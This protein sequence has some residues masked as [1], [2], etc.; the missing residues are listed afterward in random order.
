MGKTRKHTNRKRQTR[1]YSG[2]TSV[3]RKMKGGLIDPPKSLRPG[4][5][6]MKTENGEEYYERI[7]N[8]VTTW[9]K[10]TGILPRGWTEEVDENGQMYY[11]QPD[12]IST[13]NLPQETMYNGSNLEDEDEDEEETLGPSVGPRGFEL[14]P[15]VAKQAPVEQPLSKEQL[16]R[17]D[18]LALVPD[19]IMYE[20]AKR[21]VDQLWKGF[22]CSGNTTSIP[23]T[24]SSD[25]KSQ[26]TMIISKLQTL[27][28]QESTVNTLAKTVLRTV[29]APQVASKE[30]T[31]TFLNTL[32]EKGTLSV[33]CK[34]AKLLALRII[35]LLELNPPEYSGEKGQKHKNANT[36]KANRTKYKSVANSFGINTNV[37]E[38]FL[39]SFAEK[40]KVDKGNILK[41]L[42]RSR[43][44]EPKLGSYF[45]Y[46]MKEAERK[47]EEARRRG[48]AAEKVAEGS[49]SSG[50]D[51]Y[52]FISMLTGGPG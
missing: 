4:W 47:A 16:R 13:W 48:A 31:I 3:A 34:E 17:K 2:R 26:I 33:T 6:S 49:S 21:I 19:I 12:G 20:T 23:I 7:K 9:N 29:V 35:T 27:S 36:R 39:D 24:I 44:S 22:S 25:E 30:N 28:I 42:N 11:I 41:A 5:K 45:N 1:K 40:K 50:S 14:K 43:Q 10:P 15:P 37:L 32:K 46:G 52:Q 38:P 8:G 18:L 51:A